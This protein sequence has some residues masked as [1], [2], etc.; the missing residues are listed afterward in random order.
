MTSLRPIAAAAVCALAAFG[1]HAGVAIEGS[2]AGPDTLSRTTA[3]R[4]VVEP[5][6]IGHIQ[7]IP[8]YSTNAG[9]QTLLAVTNEDVVNGKV[10]K[11][12]FRSMGNG[13]T[14]YD[15]TL[16]LGPGD[17]WTANI[18]QDSDGKAR[19]RTADTSCTAPYVSRLGDGTP[20]VTNELPP[21]TS[22][23][24]EAGRDAWTREGFVEVINAAD[25]PPTLNAS[26]RA[27]QANPLFTA[28]REA[29]NGVP[30]CGS[31]ELGVLAN[32]V[33]NE[34]DAASK[35]LDTPSGGLSAYAFIINTRSA[36]VAWSVEATSLR[37]VTGQGKRGR[38]RL[39]VS[40]QTADT[41]EVGKAR[42][43][44][45]DPLLTQARMDARQ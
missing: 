13:D 35:G 3:E 45:A 12:R 9:N 42:L 33:L 14:V 5:Q 43:L 22:S 36:F 39:V 19:M 44:T 8:Y 10:V 6:G 2:G 16:F 27:G 24:T 34:A 7:L 11:V 38:G 17:A 28:S 15:F 25:I 1:A 23:F 18:S 21:V 37:A 26:G 41:V 29:G 20:F 30:T 31:A 32:D 4:M 40:P